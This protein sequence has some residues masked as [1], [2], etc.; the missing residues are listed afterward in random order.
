MPDVEHRIAVY[1][2]ATGHREEIHFE[3]L[4]N[5]NRFADA[6]LL[7]LYD[8]SE[9]VR[10]YPR[11]GS[12][13]RRRH[14]YSES[15]GQRV[16]DGGERNPTHDSRVAKILESLTCLRGGW[17]LAYQPVAAEPPVP[18]FG[19]LPAYVW[20][21]EVTRILSQ[22]ACVR[23][24]I[25]GDWGIHMSVRRP[26]IAIEVVHS[27]YPEE[28]TFEALLAQSTATPL[29]VLFDFTQVSRN[30]LVVVDEENQRLTFRSYTFS[31]SDG[32]VWLGNT[33]RDDIATSARLRV[34]VAE[35]YKGWG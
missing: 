29:V 22:R 12:A 4:E 30:R 19:P 14:F 8:E 10:V 21:A 32:S 1:W 6:K 20:D 16:F 27:H 34:A 2:D 7:E 5:D 28:S 18:L 24:D 15:N 9:Q 13:H 33:R 23:H 25:F 17:R 3:E 26:A 31:I 35:R 11:D